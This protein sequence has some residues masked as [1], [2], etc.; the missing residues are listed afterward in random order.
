MRLSLDFLTCRTLLYPITE[1]MVT[2]HNR[3]KG[4]PTA[5]PPI[6][7]YNVAYRLSCPPLAMALLAPSTH[8][9]LPSLSICASSDMAVPRLTTARDLDLPS[10][11]FPC[12]T[13]HRFTE[14]GV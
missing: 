7:Q 8:P 11:A 14:C 9:T 6:A 2:L 13:L 12:L 10:L 4:M 1:S 3:E 5:L